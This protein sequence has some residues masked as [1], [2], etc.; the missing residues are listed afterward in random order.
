MISTAAIVVKC[1][2]GNV[3]NLHFRTLCFLHFQCFTRFGTVCWFTHLQELAALN[4]K[5]FTI[6]HCCTDL[7]GKKRLYSFFERQN[8][9]V[10]SR[11][12]KIP[13]LCVGFHGVIWTWFNDDIWWFCLIEFMIQ[14]N[15]HHPSRTLDLKT[16]KDFLDHLVHPKTGERFCKNPGN[17]PQKSR[18]P[19][20]KIREANPK[21]LPFHRGRIPKMGVVYLQNYEIPWVILRFLG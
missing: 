12:I 17:Q 14:N 4:L 20:P 5:L 3:K 21:N 19:T 16:S 8:Y 11:V 10:I 9:G 15:T 1:Q 7:A 2:H 13:T 6:I 18:K